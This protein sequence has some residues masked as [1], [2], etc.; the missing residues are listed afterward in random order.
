M[1]NGFFEEEGGVKVVLVIDFVKEIDKE[2]W[3]ILRFQLEI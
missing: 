3:E 2:K 1:V